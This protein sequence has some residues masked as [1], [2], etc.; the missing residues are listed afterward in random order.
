MKRRTFVGALLAGVAATAVPARLFAAK[1]SPS[2]WDE[3]RRRVGPRLIP[4][5][6]PLVAAAHSSGAGVTSTLNTS[7]T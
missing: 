7:A 2:F 4:V 5:R 6:S 3:L 1:L